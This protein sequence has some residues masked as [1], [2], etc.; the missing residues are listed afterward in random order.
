MQVRILVHGY[1]FTKLVSVRILS[2]ATYNCTGI[3]GEM[4]AAELLV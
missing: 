3:P 1:G 4:Y 2:V